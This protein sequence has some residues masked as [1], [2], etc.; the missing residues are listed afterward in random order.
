MAKNGKA[1]DRQHIYTG[2]K[3]S[4]HTF[5]FWAPTS[6]PFDNLPFLQEIKGGSSKFGEVGVWLVLYEIPLF[7]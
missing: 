4:V 2:V 6:M 7:H 1:G 3:P 5:N